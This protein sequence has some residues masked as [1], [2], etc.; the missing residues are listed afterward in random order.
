MILTI[1]LFILL[2]GSPKGTIVINR[3]GDEDNFL[4]PYHKKL[5]F[6]RNFL[7]VVALALVSVV[8]PVNAQVVLDTTSIS[9][10]EYIQAVHRRTANYDY[11]SVE[12]DGRKVLIET[13]PNS[14]LEIGV[15]TG[16]DLF[17][18]MLTPTIGGE[19]GYHGKRFSFSV[20]TSFGM[21]EFNKNSEKAGQKYLT[22]NFGLDAGVRLFD[23]PSRYLH[24]RE[25]W[26]IGQFGYKVRKN[27]NA[28]TADDYNGDLT[29]EVKGSTMTFGGGVRV[30][31]KSYMRRTN[32]YVKALAYTGHEYFVDG[33]ESR[34][35]AS[36]TIGVNFVMG[37]KAY[38][39]KA[40]S[41][42]FGSKAAYKRALKAKR[43]IDKY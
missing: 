22:T 28:Y 32:V 4:S 20:N 12:V 37:K 7:F 9:D 35:G 15:N 34:F 39:E 6:M 8:N 24:Q 42:L 5:E 23:L 14:G 30:D 36:L 2:V 10:F 43:T 29:V 19:I 33:S 26:L 27:F 40:I 11:R 25:L 41:S 1:D 13:A 38:N 21:S 16:V 3:W 17:N 31:F 18:N